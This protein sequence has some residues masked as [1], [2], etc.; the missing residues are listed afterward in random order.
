MRGGQHKPKSGSVSLDVCLMGQGSIS[1]SAGGLAYYIFHRKDF[2]EEFS[3]EV[4]CSLD[5][6]NE[7]SVQCTGQAICGAE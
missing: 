1:R 3:K 7:W 6:L 4:H 2:Q 5:T